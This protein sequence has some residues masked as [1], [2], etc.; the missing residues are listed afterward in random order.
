M[1]SP[2]L[3]ERVTKN[4]LERRIKFKG[5]YNARKVVKAAGLPGENLRI[6]RQRSRRKY[7]ELRGRDA[8]GRR[9]RDKIV[10]VIEE[11][12]R[13]YIRYKRTDRR[14][15]PPFDAF[16]DS[17]E[18]ERD[19][20]PD[21]NSSRRLATRIQE[22]EVSLTKVVREPKPVYDKD[23]VGGHL[24]M[25]DGMYVEFCYDKGVVAKDQPNPRHKE[26]AG[27]TIFVGEIEVK[28]T[29][30]PEGDERNK[31]ALEAAAEIIAERLA[32]KG[33]EVKTEIVDID[34][35]L[36]LRPAVASSKYKW[37]KR[38]ERGLKRK[39]HKPARLERR[40]RKAA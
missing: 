7:T 34:G 26:L 22:K 14:P 36:V 2:D 3:G 5:I 12:G 29:V 25:P 17:E 31:F 37:L 35:D 27:E 40:F 11:N 4:E 6:F 39:Q 20:D 15:D 32:K 8:S 1:K 10:E 30:A 28:R 33:I 21:S 19:F 16:S 23:K 9:I 18:V 24:L 38:L 13:N